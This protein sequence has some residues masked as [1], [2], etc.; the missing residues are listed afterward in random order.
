MTSI[1]LML[2]QES[3]GQ[4]HYGVLTSMVPVKQQ[5]GLV[6]LDRISK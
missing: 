2:L 3:P 5:F 4:A 1:A 6:L